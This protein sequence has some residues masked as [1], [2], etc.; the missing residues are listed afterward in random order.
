MFLS[1]GQVES[2]STPPKYYVVRCLC[3][4]VVSR[5]RIFEE[6]KRGTRDRRVILESH[7]R[8]GLVKRTSEHDWRLLQVNYY[9]TCVCADL[10]RALIG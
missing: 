6:I 10:T 1:E 9:M 7:Q 5:Q 4:L 8:Q 3:F 2:R